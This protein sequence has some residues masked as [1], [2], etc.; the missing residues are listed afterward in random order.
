MRSRVVL[1]LILVVLQSAP[2]LGQHPTE[3]ES[4]TARAEH[5]Q[6]LAAF[7]KMPAR[8]VT[9]SALVA[10]GRSAWA[11]GLTER[12]AEEFDRAL[13]DQSLDRIQRARILLS[14]GIME[15]Q[16]GQYP[17][18][19][20]YAEKSV[21]ALDQP[22][23]LRAKG[24]LL[25]A[26]SLKQLRA[27]GAALER[28]QS[29]LTE[30]GPEEKAEIYFLLGECQ[31]HLGRLEE[32]RLSLENIALSHERAPAAMRRLAQIA[33]D[34]QKYSQA[35]YWLEKGRQEFPDNFVD[36]WV[37]YAL[38]VAASSVNDRTKVEQIQQAAAKKCPPS[39]HWLI[40]L[41]SAA[42]AFLWKESNSRPTAQAVS[43]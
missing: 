4:K 41:N 40:L 27:Y 19:A 34:T 29:A 26:E 43:G 39:D 24:W 37:D 35:I 11:L 36:S 42:E 25:W 38:T 23:P 33:L 20:L 15:Y 12:A 3:V 18:S 13:L 1:V 5:L 10:A 17:V 9:S 14:R 6:A 2:A 32:A 16:R 21:A 30:A 7:D 22:S 8:R 31:M 28:Y